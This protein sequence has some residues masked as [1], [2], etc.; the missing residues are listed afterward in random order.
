M[1][2]ID[3]SYIYEFSSANKPINSVKLNETF[4][5]KTL[6]CYGG[7]LKSESDLR[8]DF[9]NL[10]INPAT[11]PI[12]I[13]NIE[14]GDTISIDIKRIELN[15]QGV[16]ATGPDTGILGDYITES[17]TKIL[18]ITDGCALLNN[19]IKI[20]INKM[21]GVIGVAPE[22][23]AIPCS[24]PDIHGGNMDTKDITEGSTLHLPVFH[25]GG[26]LALGDLHAAMG[27]G[28][29]D[30]TGIEIGGEVTLQIKKNDN[31]KLKTPIVETDTHFMVIASAEA[32]NDAVRQ[33]MLNAI[34]LLQHKHQI[35][36]ADAYRLLSAKGD[37]RISQ[38]VNPKVTVRMALP[39]TVLVNL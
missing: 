18:P 8:A 13:E 14:K 7:Q 24:T 1:Q 30:G 16:M 37:L 39:K 4:S 20:P 26:L 34:S 6:D 32:F 12:Y 11:G 33:G 35:A 21:I 2:T 19:Q 9:P 22:D 31:F 25:E 38:L 29:L 23:H 10:K 15:D 17:Q 28:E 5:I 27:D 3:G 36:F